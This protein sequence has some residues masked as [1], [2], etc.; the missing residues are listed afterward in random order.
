V[1]VGPCLRRWLVNCNSLCSYEQ[2]WLWTQF[3]GMQETT[4]TVHAA[5]DFMSQ[6]AAAAAAWNISIQYCMA[7]PRH[8][9][10]ASAFTSVTHIRVRFTSPIP[11]LRISHPLSSLQRRLRSRV[12]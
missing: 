10:A 2:D 4:R 12:T 3:L 5:D 1:S 11:T 9:L 7:L 6:M 8:A